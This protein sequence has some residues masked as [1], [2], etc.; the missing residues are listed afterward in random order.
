MGNSKIFTDIAIFQFNLLLLF[1]L[2]CKRIY[3]IAL[4]LGR[5]LPCYMPRFAY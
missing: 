2:M 5:N 1:N 4:K 3:M